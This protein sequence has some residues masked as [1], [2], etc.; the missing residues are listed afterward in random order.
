MA[1]NDGVVLRVCV[2]DGGEGGGR[3]KRLEVKG[4]E[5]HLGSEGHLMSRYY[6]YP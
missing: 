6:N 4:Q 3:D 5:C 1:R 2:G